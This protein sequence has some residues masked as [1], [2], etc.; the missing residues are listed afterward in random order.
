MNIDF[1]NKTTK[2]LLAAALVL[3]ASAAGAVW[4]YSKTR[5]Q[6]EEVKAANLVGKTKDEVISWRDENHLPETQLTFSYEFS[7][8]IKNDI[9]LSQ[10]ITPDTEIK[11]GEVLD[12][13]LSKGPDP[14]K[15]FD[16]PDFTGKKKDEISKWFEDN[17]YKNV[18]YQFRA[19]AKI[20]TDMFIS[21]NPASG[22]VKRS[23]EIKVI[24]S[25]GGSEQQKEITV[26]DFSS[27]SKNN[28]QAWAAE[29][30]VTLIFKTQ[31]SDKV[32]VGKMI[33]QSVK[34]GT[35]VKSGASITITL[36]SGKGITV[37][38][39]TGKKKTE[40]QAW[41]AGVNLKSTYTEVYSTSDIGTVVSQNPASGTVAEETSIVFTI[42]AGQVP[43]KNCIGQTESSF[44]NYINGLNSEKNSSAK[45]T[46]TSSTVESDSTAGT[47]LS[48]S[49][50]GK[51]LTDTVYCAP[52]SKIAVTVAVGRQITVN[53]KTG[54]SETDF[55]N[56]LASL[57]MGIGTRTETYSSSVAAGLIISNDTGTKA[58]G[59]LIS[60]I[61]SKGA[62]SLNPALYAAGA[63]YNTLSSEVARAN[64]LGAGISLAKSTAGSTQYE[65]GKIISCSVSGASIS[66]SV[67]SGI[68]VT[69][70]NVT[71]MTVDQAKNALSGFNVSVSS[72][73]YSDSVAANIVVGQSLSAGSAVPQG[74]AI[75]LTYSEGPKPVVKKILPLI[76]MN[77]YS[78]LE[79]QNIESQI[80]ETLANAGFSNVTFNLMFD[81]QNPNNFKGVDSI[82]PNCDGVT[83]ADVNTAITVNILAVRS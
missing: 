83:E 42:S 52:G 7:E 64:S 39:F 57:G 29:N 33:S 59:T 17:L 19:D 67:S 65:A 16:L 12:I 75:S 74:A 68:V 45:L 23:D 55:K 37:S 6:A 36:S 1:S 72:I 48:Q 80:S 49:V 79:Y 56:Y 62:Y 61:V 69:V 11:I 41:A 82:S 21:M 43:V 28:M 15:E 46:Y 5:T 54:V 32:A 20:K 60:Y 22:K 8:D 77:L 27:Y 73:G 9:V 76:Y 47:I 51:A 34:A 78:G 30:K 58:K 2:I 66:C 53:S 81:D 14:D 26:P 70:P 10:S 18:Q 40:A 24:L 3:T 38:D 35:S 4:Y 71:G 50:N 13:S 44:K 31:N 25:S 63:S